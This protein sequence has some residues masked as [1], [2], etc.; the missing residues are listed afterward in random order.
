MPGENRNNFKTDFPYAV[1]ELGKGT[2][3][4]QTEGEK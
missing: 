2:A 3:K 1:S 4:G